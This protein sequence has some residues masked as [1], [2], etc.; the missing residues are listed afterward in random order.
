MG[1]LKLLTCGG[2]TCCEFWTAG[3]G[4]VG[5]CDLVLWNLELRTGDRSRWEVRLSLGTGGCLVLRVGQVEEVGL[6]W[7]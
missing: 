3:K 6:Y 2:R 4:R 1:Q 7:L 5:G